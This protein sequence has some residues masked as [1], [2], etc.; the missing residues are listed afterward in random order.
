MERVN[1]LGRTRTGL[2]IALETFEREAKRNAVKAE[3]ATDKR[4]RLIYEVQSLEATR[5]AQRLVRSA[6]DGDG[7][8]GVMRKTLRDLAQKYD[9]LAKVTN[10]AVERAEYA[11]RSAEYKKIEREI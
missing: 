1:C 11:R 2:D 5:H 7:V 3:L 4:Q 9:I 8:K 10:D 6:K